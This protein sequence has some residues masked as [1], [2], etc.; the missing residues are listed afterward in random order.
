MWM[1]MSIYDM[2]G[3]SDDYIVWW[4]RIENCWPFRR[5]SRRA[6][7][8]PR[9]RSLTSTSTSLTCSRCQHARKGLTCSGRCKTRCVPSQ[10]YQSDSTPH[11]HS[12]FPS[13]S[14]AG[15]LFINEIFFNY[16][17]EDHR[18]PSPTFPHAADT[19]P[20]LLRCPRHAYF[21]L[22]LPVSASQEDIREA[23]RKCS[24]K[25]HPDRNPQ[26]RER[27]EKINVGKCGAI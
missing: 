2:N 8:R 12:F 1:Y 20:L 16:T 11:L 3:G 26:S 4:V 14:Q 10:R 15:L 13:L 19:R 23:F 9:S 24:K 25:Y 27:F 17:Y 21:Y 18:L 5:R 22:E 6:W 7:L